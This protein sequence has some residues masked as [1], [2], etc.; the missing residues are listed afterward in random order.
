MTFLGL[1]HQPLQ[2]G[3]NPVSSLDHSFLISNLKW[4]FSM[5]CTI[6]SRSNT[7][8]TWLLFPHWMDGW[9][10]GGTL[11][12][13]SGQRPTDRGKGWQRP[14]EPDMTINK[15]KE[16]KPHSS[17]HGEESCIWKQE[18]TREDL[19]KHTH[20]FK[21]IFAASSVQ[22]KKE[23]VGLEGELFIWMNYNFSKVCNTCYVFIMLSESV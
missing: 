20:N 14:S 22:V 19:G 23:V 9:M 3:L 2:F 15:P 10:W 4:W 16:E 17:A 8:R 11:G 13:R 1:K 21:W 6:P 12:F 5:T 18:A 7:S